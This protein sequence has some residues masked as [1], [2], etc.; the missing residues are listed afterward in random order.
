MRARLFG[1]ALVG[2]L[3]IGLWYGARLLGE[4]V[5]PG[6][7]WHFLLPVPHEILR[8]GF[9][10]GDLLLAAAMETLGQA[11]VGFLLAAAGGFALA[12]VL[13]SARAARVALY[14]WVLVMQMVP[15]IVLVPLFAIW[16]GEGPRSVGAI[17]FV[18][19]FFPIV[20]NTAQGMLSVEGNQR[21]L[22]R[23]Y[24]ATYWQTMWLLRLPA[25]L[26]YFFTG[27][28]IAG[29][30]A[31]IGAL[32]GEMFAGSSAGGTGGLG[33]LIITFKGRGWIDAML[34][35]GLLACAL[36]FVFVGAVSLARGW[37][38]RKWHP[39]AN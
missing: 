18:I 17:T 28:R 7:T 9:A 23:L 19:S 27:M 35:A 30:L 37:A 2:L 24:D 16:F 4:A 34:A 33:F 26:P 1:P 25:S 38:L 6:A 10:R 21:E 15:V 13:A 29:S 8:A 14:P 31:M 11:A 12:F 32:T 36:G 22:F 5:N 39:S 20:A 3:L